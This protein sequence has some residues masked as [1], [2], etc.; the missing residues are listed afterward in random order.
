M[1]GL[2]ERIN[3]VKLLRLDTQSRTNMSEN[4]P[5]LYNAV[6]IV[7]NAKPLKLE[8]CLIC[9]NVKDKA[10]SFKLTNLEDGR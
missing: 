8:L 1:L 5:G 9:Q 4:T 3:K 10:G 7:P 6:Q 2:G